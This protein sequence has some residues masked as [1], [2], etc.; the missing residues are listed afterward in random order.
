MHINQIEETRV[1][2]THQRVNRGADL[3]LTR[4]IKRFDGRTVL[5]GVDLNIRPGEFVAVVGR[6][7]CG[8]STLLRAIA[9]LETPDEGQ[10]AIQGAIEGAAGAMPDVRMMFQDARLLPWK[11]VLQNVMLGLKDGEEK[12]R[13]R[14][15]TRRVCCY[16]TSRWG[17]WTPSRASRCSS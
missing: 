1:S 12:A 2:E 16:W 3:R 11:T 14:W 13:A 17:R 5:D 6:S 10:V 15:C 9:G 7:G 4:L 8:K